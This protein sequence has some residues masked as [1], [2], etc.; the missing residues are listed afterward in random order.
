MTANDRTSQKRATIAAGKAAWHSAAQI[1]ATMQATRRRETRQLC[2][3]RVPGAALKEVQAGQQAHR[4]AAMEILTICE[5]APEI[6]RDPPGRWANLRVLLVQTS[7][8]GGGVGVGA[9]QDHGDAFSVTGLVGASEQ[10]GEGG[11]PAVLHG[12]AVLV[13]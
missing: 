3:G 11:G 10:G 13:P 12:Q 6:E 2:A 9:A 8:Q 7:G 4:P 1:L 5:P